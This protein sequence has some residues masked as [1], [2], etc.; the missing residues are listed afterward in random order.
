MSRRKEKMS[1]RVNESA[2]E[3]GILGT[4]PPSWLLVYSKPCVF[5][6]LH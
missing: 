3:R 1:E 4:P 5:T 6:T 2:G